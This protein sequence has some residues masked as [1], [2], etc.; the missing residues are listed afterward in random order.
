VNS[1]FTPS[2][3]EG[4]LILL[5]IAAAFGWAYGFVGHVGYAKQVAYTDP[6]R[7]FAATTGVLV[8]IGL[9]IFYRHIINGQLLDALQQSF[10]QTLNNAN[11]W[12][13]L[14]FWNPTHAPRHCGRPCGDDWRFCR[15]CK[16]D[17]AH[18]L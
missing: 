3:I 6:E 8:G 9:V 17:R 4:T 12:V 5:P 14:F 18:P 15:C 10:E 11:P 16:G 13:M 7:S 1:L 2:S